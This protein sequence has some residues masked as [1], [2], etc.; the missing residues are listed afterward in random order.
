MRNDSPIFQSTS[1]SHVWG[2][3][4]TMK[5]HYG[6]Q[7]CA[8]GTAPMAVTLPS[9]MAQAVKA[10]PITFMPS[11]SHQYPVADGSPKM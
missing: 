1:F 6:H 9:P 5:I 11:K 3:R 2:R 4:P 7:L 10:D 8:Y